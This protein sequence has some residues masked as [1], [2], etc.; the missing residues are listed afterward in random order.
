MAQQQ[1]ESID[2]IPLQPP[3][4]SPYN[5]RHSAR[6]SAIG[7]Q[8]SRD[9]SRKRIQRSRDAL[10]ASLNLAAPPHAVV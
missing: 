9:A 5:T 2:I 6:H 4:S 3:T 1:S 8:A 10:E 7:V